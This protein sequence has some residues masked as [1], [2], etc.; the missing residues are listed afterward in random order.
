MVFEKWLEQHLLL[1]L[2]IP[3]VLIMDNLPVHRK[4]LIRESAD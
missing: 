3:S 1:P 4:N 2:T